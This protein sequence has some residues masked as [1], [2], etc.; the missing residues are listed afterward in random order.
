MAAAKGARGKERKSLQDADAYCS[1]LQVLR[2]L[3]VDAGDSGAAAKSN[4][5]LPILPPEE[6]VCMGVC[7]ENKSERE[8]V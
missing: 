5:A 1:S 7:E 3:E 6:R 4:A 2:A 8:G